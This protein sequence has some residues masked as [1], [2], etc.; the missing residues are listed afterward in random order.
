MLLLNYMTLEHSPSVRHEQSEKESIKSYANEAEKLAP[1]FERMET[2]VYQVLTNHKIKGVDR[3]MLFRKIIGE[4]TRRN[5][6]KKP[7][8]PSADQMRDAYAHQMRQPRD[9]W[10]PDAEE[11]ARKPLYPNEET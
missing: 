4:I 2:A 7:T 8:E 9:T 5:K 10:D 3:T 6:A 11:E 1:K